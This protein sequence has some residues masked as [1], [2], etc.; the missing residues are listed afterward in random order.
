MLL[1]TNLDDSS[2]EA[3]GYCTEKLWQAGALDVATS[4]LQMKKS[5][6]GILLS[7]QCSPV[8]ADKLADILFRETTTLGL[9]RSTCH[10]QTL[11]RRTV[12][13]STVW[14]EIAGIV[15]TLPDLSERFSPEYDSCREIADREQVPLDAVYAAARQAWGSD[16]GNDE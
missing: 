1:E 4:P 13:I 2:G 10:R 15:A 11:P 16:R 6:P 12:Q 5:R 7:V 8:D 14:G 9:R 3:I